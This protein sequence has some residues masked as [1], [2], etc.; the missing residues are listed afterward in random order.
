MTAASRILEADRQARWRLRQEQGTDKPKRALW[1]V[2]TL[3]RHL[4]PEDVA[5]AHHLAGLYAI[6]EGVREMHDAVDAQSSDRHI[7]AICDAHRKLA[8]YEGVV[9]SKLTPAA[10]RCMW[11]IAYSDDIATTARAMGFHPKSK[12]AVTKIVQLTLMALT[13]YRDECLAAQQN[14]NDAA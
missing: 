7:V 13:E 8:A 9:R 1:V 2:S 5:T 6:T 3:R 14:W 11:S 10:V 12:G 4:S